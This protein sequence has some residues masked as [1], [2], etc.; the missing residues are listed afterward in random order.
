MLIL[1]SLEPELTCLNCLFL[2]ITNACNHQIL[3]TTIPSVITKMTMHKAYT[4]TE[5]RFV[6]TPFLSKARNMFSM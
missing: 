3:T 2:I 1:I 4:S 6:L 5:Q